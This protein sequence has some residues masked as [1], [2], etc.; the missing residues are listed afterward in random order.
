MK[1]LNSADKIVIGAGAGLTASAGIDYGDSSYFEANYQPFLK[2]GLKTVSEAVSRYW[3]LDDD[4][5]CSFWAFWAYHI[6]NVFY[7]QQQLGIY[8]Q[9]YEII[10]NKNY[11]IISTNADGQ[12]LK[13][14]FSTDR[15]LTLHGSY[16]KI[17]C[18]H[19]CLH[20]T[21][22]SEQAVSD[23]M[24]SFNP[25]TLLVDKTSLPIC[26]ECGNLMSP[27]LRVDRYFVETPYL[28]SRDNYHDFINVTDEN[29]MFIELGVGIKDDMMIQK[30]FEEMLK[31]YKNAK[32]VKIDN[33]RQILNGDNSSLLR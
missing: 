15:V 24:T 12:F 4:N 26:L 25:E 21:C 1:D 31:L 30:P 6:N 33:Y 13:G 11:F 3:N 17:Q 9:L 14:G 2:A 19:G 23:M 28:K 18:R 8:K 22:S 29:I 20:R 16:D 7:Q 27:N 5:A 10:K 32:L